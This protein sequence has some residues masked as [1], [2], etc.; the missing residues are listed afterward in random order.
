MITRLVDEKAS[1]A[2]GLD[3][4]GVIVR[5]DG[6][7]VRTARAARIRHTAQSDAAVR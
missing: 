4:N 3:E 2:I 1:R 5:P 6:K 7:Y